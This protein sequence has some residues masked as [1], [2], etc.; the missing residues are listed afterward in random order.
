MQWIDSK[1]MFGD[2]DAHIDNERQF[3]D[4]ANMY[5]CLTIWIPT[6]FY[7][8]EVPVSLV[9]MSVIRLMPGSGRDW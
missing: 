2:P 1:A 5:D 6:L 9:C 8:A 3:R 7:T 4:Y